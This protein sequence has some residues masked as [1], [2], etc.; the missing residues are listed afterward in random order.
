V[1]DRVSRT[2]IV[3]VQFAVADRIAALLL[4]EHLVACAQCSG[5][6][7]SRYH[8]KGSEETAEEWLVLAKTRAGLADRVV[9]RIVAEHPYEVPEVIVLPVVGGA[10]AYFD[11]VDEV[12]ADAD[13]V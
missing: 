3:Q 10:A 4:S 1:L 7:T 8:W 2:D 6:I 13:P 5:P 9:E 12:T 11:W